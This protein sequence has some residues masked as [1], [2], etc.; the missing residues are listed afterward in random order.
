MPDRKSINDDLVTVL[1]ETEITVPNQVATLMKDHN[2]AADFTKEMIISK[3]SELTGGHKLN[4]EDIKVD[5][6]LSDGNEISMQGTVA[7]PATSS[8]MQ[9]ADAD[10]EPQEAVF[11]VAQSAGHVEIVGVQGAGKGVRQLG[12]VAMQLEDGG[13][14][15]TVKDTAN[16]PIMGIFQNKNSIA[17][18]PAS[19]VSMS[20][21]KRL[22]SALIATSDKSP[23]Q[24]AEFKDMLDPSKIV[25]N[26]SVEEIDMDVPVKSP[27]SKRSSGPSGP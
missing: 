16:L 25:V 3:S 11:K 24:L 8:I 23:Q 15:I 7:L 12:C 2:Y 13:V 5:I 20:V 17:M 14:R 22:D 19:K 6:L 21:D 26:E 1:I 4:P 27:E 18:K 10:N 9:T